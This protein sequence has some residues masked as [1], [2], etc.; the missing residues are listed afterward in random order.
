[1]E[2]KHS[3]RCNCHNN[4]RWFLIYWN[5]CRHTGSFTKIWR[6]SKAFRE[7]ENTMSYDMKNTNGSKNIAFTEQP[8]T[9]Y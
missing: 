3:P 8:N 6:G 1:M 4:I 7:E 9:H 5:N 2:T